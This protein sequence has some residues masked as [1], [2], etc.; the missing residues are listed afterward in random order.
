MSTKGVTILATIAVLSC[1]A[2]ARPFGAKYRADVWDFFLFV[3]EHP[4]GNCESINQAHGGCAFPKNA[5]TFTMHGIWPT[6]TGTLGPNFC[7]P[8]A[9]FDPSEIESILPAL[10]AG[11][12][13]MLLDTSFYSFWCHEWLKHG[14]C[15]SGI[16]EMSTEFKFFNTTLGLLEKYNFT[17]VLE[18][19]DITPSNTTTYPMAAFT[20]AFQNV[21]GVEP[22]LECTSSSSTGQVLQQVSICLQK[23]FTIMACDKS[24]FSS[25]SICKS[26]EDIHYVGPWY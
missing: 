12:T 10:V 15:A 1:A 19:N 4:S 11:W 18:S 25:S 20:K 6:L 22:L 21:Y 16:A 13:N 14:T 9:I 26:T 23:D 17:S 8:S 24:V 5:S 7:D 3:Q 2:Q